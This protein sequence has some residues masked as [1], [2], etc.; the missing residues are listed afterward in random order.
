MSLLAADRE[1]ALAAL[2]QMNL[3]L[4]MTGAD[5]LEGYVA[6]HAERIRAWMRR[7]AGL[8]PA[9]HARRAF[10]RPRAEVNA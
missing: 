6:G 4:N 7:P 8:S 9:R 10:A 3:T 5:G 2:H 1:V